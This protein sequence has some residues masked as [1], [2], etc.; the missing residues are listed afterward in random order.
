[1]D[2]TAITD[3]ADLPERGTFLFTVTEPGGYEEE[4]ILARVDDSDEGPT[5]DDSPNRESD[6]EATTDESGDGTGTDESADTPAV[7][8]WKNYCTHEPDQRL[9]RG[10]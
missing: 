3:V 1:M 7:V 4:V 6:G 8:A 2:A 10:G 5:A 9:D